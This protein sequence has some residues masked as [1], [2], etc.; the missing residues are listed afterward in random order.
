MSNNLPRKD[1]LVIEFIDE[2]EHPIDKNMLN[3]LSGSGVSKTKNGDVANFSSNL[4]A[5]INISNNNYEKN[6]TVNQE[7]SKSI[8]GSLDITKNKQNKDDD[9]NHDH[10]HEAE[11]CDDKE[12]D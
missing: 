4:E 10:D 9:N 6:P 5:N 8:I 2:P 3:S 12:Y 1:S 11:S 7:F